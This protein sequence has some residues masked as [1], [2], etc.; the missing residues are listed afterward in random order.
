[1]NYDFVY[2]DYVEGVPEEQAH[3]AA[4][5]IQEMFAGWQFFLF[6]HGKYAHMK[7]RTR[8][9]LGSV[10]G[11]NAPPPSW[12]FFNARALKSPFEIGPRVANAFVVAHHSDRERLLG[13]GDYAPDFVFDYPADSVVLYPFQTLIVGHLISYYWGIARR[14]I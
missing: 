2:T 8:H 10:L 3:K 4:E 1:G 9:S 11:H 14:R 13:M 6:Q 5:M 7:R 12:P